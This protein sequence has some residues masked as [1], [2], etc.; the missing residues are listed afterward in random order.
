MLVCYIHYIIIHNTSIRISISSYN[1]ICIQILSSV[2]SI[3]CSSYVE[4]PN[5]FYFYI[6]LLRLLSNNNKAEI[7]RRETRVLLLAS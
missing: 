2:C 7:D 5:N 4:N 6:L 3:R 1:A